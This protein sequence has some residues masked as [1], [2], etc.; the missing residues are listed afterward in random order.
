MD[1]AVKTPTLKQI[2]A[3]VKPDDTADQIINKVCGNLIGSGKFRDVYELKGNPDYVVKFERDPSLARF[4]NVCEWINWKDNYEWDY[5]YPWLCPC[6]DITETGQF[7]IQRRAQPLKPDQLPEKVPSLFTDLK[8]ENFGWLENRIVIL[9][10]SFF[11]IHT[12]TNKFKK[13]KWRFPKKKNR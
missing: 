4:A 5:L 6:V 3:E 8:P 1:S 11:A 10:Y 13:A 7:L 12:P 2:W 9:D